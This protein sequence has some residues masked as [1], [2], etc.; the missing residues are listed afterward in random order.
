MAGWMTV[1]SST[2]KGCGFNPTLGRFVSQLRYHFLYPTLLVSFR[3]D[4]ITSI[5]GCFILSGA[6]NCVNKKCDAGFKCVTC[7]GLYNARK[8]KLLNKL[9]DFE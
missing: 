9:L 8:V 6:Y 3:G 5:S 7:R 4:T 1:F 2:L